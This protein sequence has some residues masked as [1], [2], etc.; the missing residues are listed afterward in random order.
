VPKAV[1]VDEPRQN[2]AA[3]A[4]L[5]RAPHYSIERREYAGAKP[6]TLILQISVP[7][8][9]FNWAEMI[10]LAC[11]LISDFPKENAVHALL[12][13]DR[14][15]ARSLALYHT[16]QSHQGTYLWHLRARFELDREKNEQFIEFLNPE[17]KDGLL[18]VKRTR[19]WISSAN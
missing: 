6:T 18:S 3:I 2:C 8:E 16:D 17:V 11:K 19:I 13:D 12:F 7:T 15:A 1:K 9:A 14:K 4:Q 5:G 10:Q